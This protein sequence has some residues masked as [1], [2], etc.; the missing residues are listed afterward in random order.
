MPDVGNV[1]CRMLALLVQ[2]PDTHCRVV[3]TLVCLQHFG[4][5]SRFIQF[6]SMLTAHPDRS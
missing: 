5:Y 2:S 6:H 3:A 1:C 4:S